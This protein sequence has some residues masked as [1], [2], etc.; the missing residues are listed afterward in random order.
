VNLHQIALSSGP[1]VAAGALITLAGCA[2]TPA[3]D[4]GPVSGIRPT[5]TNGVVGVGTPTQANLNTP[6]PTI[7]ITVSSTGVSSTAS[8]DPDGP[9]LVGVGGEDRIAVLNTDGTGLTALEHEPLW[10]PYPDVR[11]GIEASQLG[12]IAVR[13]SAS[14]WPDP[15]T[16]ISL[17]LFHLPGVRPIKRI[18]LFSPELLA[19]MDEVGEYLPPY[20]PETVEG[21]NWQYDVVYLTVLAERDP[22]LW[23]PDGR[24][25]AFTGAIDGPSSDLYV[26]DTQT[27]QERRLTDGPNQAAILGWSPDSQWII[28]SESSTY[29]IADGGEIGGFP[30]DA[31]WAAAADGSEVRRLYGPAGVEWVLGWI[32]D[33]QF[34]VHRWSGYIFLHDLQVVDVRTGV[35]RNI[36]SGD[37]YNSVLAPGPRMVVVDAVTEGQSDN[38]L[39]GGLQLIPMDGGRPKPLRPGV[40]ALNAARLEWIAP[41]GQFLGGGFGSPFLFTSAGEITQTF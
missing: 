35:F 39:P 10:D 3:P 5:T 28:H 13:T 34:L 12:W 2:G 30:A 36:Y 41:L 23:S 37:V 11:Q 21:P 14:A 26:Y 27:D 9:W 15:P 22:P 4:E 31:V 6:G 33:T 7:S 25:L 29:M 40:E 32:S 24:F 18:P 19:R 38:D 20:A 16:D 17:E 8:L 1:L